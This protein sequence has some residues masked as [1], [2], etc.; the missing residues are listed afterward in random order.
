M[1]SVP[2]WYSAILIF[3]WDR[4]MGVRRNTVHYWIVILG[5]FPAYGIIEGIHCFTTLLE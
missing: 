5:M 1:A 2:F 3:V 4:D